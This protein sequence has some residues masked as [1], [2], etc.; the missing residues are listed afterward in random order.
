MYKVHFIGRGV[1]ECAEEGKPLLALARE[2]D[3]EITA[4][5]GGLGKC[6]K[7]KVKVNGEEMLACQRI[8]DG[9]L[10]LTVALM[11]IQQPTEEEPTEEQPSEEEEEQ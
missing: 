11:P 7:C 8:V 9:D 4:P 2:N 1:V 5:C 10:T 6:G 3:I